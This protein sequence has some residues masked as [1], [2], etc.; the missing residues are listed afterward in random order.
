MIQKSIPMKGNPIVSAIVVSHNQAKYVGKT[1]ESLMKQDYKNLEII[2]VDNCS[3][4]STPKIL[5]EYKKKYPYLKVILRKGFQKGPG[6]AWNLGAKN[7]K[8]K[9]FSFLAGDYIL[10]ESYM[11]DLIKPILKGKTIG[12][13]QFEE[14]IANINNLWARAFCHRRVCTVNG[15]SPTFFMIRKDAFFKYGPF[16][17]SLG[18]ADDHTIYKKHGLES[19]G[20]K[21]DIWHHN[22]DTFMET[23][24][25]DVW[26]G[27]S[28]PKP[29]NIIIIFPVFP[30]WA[31]YKTI[32][33]LAKKDFYWKF[34]FFLPVFY[35][36]KYFG[37]LKGAI[38]RLKEKR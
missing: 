6:I 38:V 4:D 12:T 2:A 21:A 30:L 18:Y 11:S 24:N 37:Y 31:V 10:G 32:I 15:K 22:R 23:W 1:I 27:K 9:I 17:P 36:L 20:V 8:G 13:I 33:H 5:K 7:A 3:T 16:D 28:N 14:K 25:H 26:V 34:I 19:F 29:F 35:T